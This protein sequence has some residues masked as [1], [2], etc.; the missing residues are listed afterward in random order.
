MKEWHI[1]HCKLP[2]LWRK[3][4]RVWRGRIL[5]KWSAL[6]A[7]DSTSENNHCENLGSWWKTANQWKQCVLRPFETQK[8]VTMLPI[9]SLHL[10]FL[11]LFSSSQLME[12]PFS[13][14]SQ[15]NTLQ[16]SL[17]PLFFSL[18]RW[19]SSADVA[20]FISKT[21][22]MCPITCY[23]HYCYHP[24]PSH[25]PFLSGT[26]VIASLTGLLTSTLAPHSL[27]STVMLLK[28]QP[29]HVTSVLRT[30]HQLLIQRKTWL[31]IMTHRLFETQSP[32]L[33]SL[34]T[35]WASPVSILCKYS[36]LFYSSH[37]GLLAVL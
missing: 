28:R 9:A 34:L 37:M 24:S 14:L 32:S 11:Q 21:H 23:C 30:L 25:P 4:H 12:T 33:T 17:T 26:T 6:A 13:T 35:S 2:C 3:K 1:Y 16:S 15:A 27:F 29:H 18:L 31:L 8:S 36:L 7:M 22:R 5:G 20:G 19:N 10:T